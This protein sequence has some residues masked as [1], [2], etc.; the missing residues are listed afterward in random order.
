MQG[1]KK[2]LLLVEDN[3]ID[4]FIIKS[5][6]KHET[7]QID[8]ITYRNGQE[9]LDFLNDI[10]GSTAPLLILLDLNMPICNGFTFM[11]KYEEKLYKKYPII[12]VYV[13]SSSFLPEDIVRCQKYPFIKDYL[14][15]PI[16]AE[17][18]RK[19]LVNLE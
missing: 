14:V 5:I 4:A 6:M 11:E 8:L 17:V 3:E 13:L 10:D 7:P 12:P 15:K 16:G 18:L 19:L 9:G 1:S 2:Y